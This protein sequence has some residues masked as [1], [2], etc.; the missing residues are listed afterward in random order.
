[1]I[2]FFL[3]AAFLLLYFILTQFLIYRIRKRNKVCDEII[4]SPSDYSLII[5]KLPENV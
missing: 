5:Q 4:N 3:I 1:M 2:Q